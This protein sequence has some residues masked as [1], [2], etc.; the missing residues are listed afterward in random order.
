MKNIIGKALINDKVED[1]ICIDTSR[2]VT[3]HK[4]RVVWINSKGLRVTSF[5]SEKAVIEC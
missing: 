1:L 2:L 5:I 3:E 4:V